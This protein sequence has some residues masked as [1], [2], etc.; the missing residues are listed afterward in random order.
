MKKL[1]TC[2]FFIILFITIYLLP[3]SLFSQY[4]LI[5]PEIEGIYLCEPIFEEGG[6]YLS[7]STLDSTVTTTFG[8]IYHPFL[9]LTDRNN[10]LYCDHIATNNWL[11]KTITHDTGPQTYVFDFEPIVYNAISDNY[12]L[13]A[14]LPISIPDTLAIGQ[15]F[16]LNTFIEGEVIS[17]N[18]ISWNNT[19]IEVRTIQLNNQGNP[20]YKWQSDNIVISKDYGLFSFPNLQYF[21][22]E[23]RNC[24][25]VGLTEPKIGVQDVTNKDIYRMSPGDE[26]TAE[27]S[28]TYAGPNFDIYYE[29]IKCLSIIEETDTSQRRIVQ[30]EIVRLT[31]LTLIWTYGI[32][33]LEQDIIY[34]HLSL[35][36]R[37][38]ET[39]Y[40]DANTA[41]Y[42]VINEAGI[43]QSLQYSS[44]DKNECFDEIIDGCNSRYSFAGGFTVYYDCSMIF[45]FTDYYLPVHRIVGGE[46]FG[47]GDIFDSFKILKSK[48]IDL[49]NVVI[50]PNPSNG[51]FSLE[52]PDNLQFD[53][54]MIAGLSG[55]TIPLI[56][57]F[58]ENKRIN[59]KQNFVPGIYVIHAI[60][61]SG[62]H[63]NLGKIT[64]L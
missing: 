28:Y 24:T 6:K 52:L 31:P 10:H 8:K 59:F 51:E 17:E 29:R 54:F 37:A 50:Y 62:K 2:P 26:F 42:I 39:I 22:F 60:D 35:R 15:K 12:Q 27:R 5:N 34:D 40:Y 1:Y 47:D 63:F 58:S 45:N 41:N 30:R 7:R 64:V 46:E 23:W 21:P 43:K 61:K 57:I 38:N 13:A 33:T 3:Y 20:N 18:F 44:W 9:T 32:D 4:K 36:G 49:P 25:L 19:Q 14:T 48:T 16:M 53:H 11:G 55:I 56:P